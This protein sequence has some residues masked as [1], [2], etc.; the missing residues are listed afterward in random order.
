[1]GLGEHWLRQVCWYAATGLLNLPDT[2]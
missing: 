2:R 1:L